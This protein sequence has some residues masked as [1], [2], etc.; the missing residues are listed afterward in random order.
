MTPHS[1]AR[2]SRCSAHQHD[3]DAMVDTQD[4]AGMGAG[5]G[6]DVTAQPTRGLRMCALTITRT[7][8]THARTTCALR[9]RNRWRAR[10]GCA[11]VFAPSAMPCQCPIAAAHIRCF[12]RVCRGSAA[13]GPAR[14]LRLRHGHARARAHRH[15]RA[16]PPVCACLQVVQEHKVGTSARAAALSSAQGVPSCTRR[17]CV[18]A[19]R[20]RARTRART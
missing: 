4:T 14:G 11:P 9:E 19:P 3:H 15:T 17:Q 1:L 16:G 5:E 8:H 2:T 6:G 10:A 7:R 12:A 13:L 18:R 20:A